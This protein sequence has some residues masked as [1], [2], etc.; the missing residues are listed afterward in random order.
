MPFNTSPTQPEVLIV[1]AGPAGLA[2]AIASARKGLHVEVVDAMQPPIDKACGEGLLPDAL[3][4]LTN[5]GFNLN[6]DLRSIETHPLRGIRFLNEQTTTEASFPATLGR[7]IRRTVLHQLLLDRALSL[8]VR[9]HWQHSVQSIEPTT[10][11]HLIRTNRQTLRTRYLIGA[12]GHHS[13]IAAWSGLTASTTH[14]R[15]IGLRQHYTI[16]PWTNF[17]EVYWSNYGQAYVTPTSPHEVCVAFVSNQKTPSTEHALAQ[18]PALQHQLTAA[19]PSGSPRGSISLNR[20]LRRVTANNIALIGDASGSVDAITG[21]G[22]GLGFSQAA[23]LAHALHTG[24]LA[25]YQRA[26]SSIQRP[27][28]I[29]SRSLLLLDRFPHLRTL[30]LNTFERHPLLF[31]H[32]LHV[33]IGHRNCPFAVLTNRLQPDYTC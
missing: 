8:G 25:S 5:L 28:R 12:D 15:R 31:E 21:S 22:L 7:G 1:G 32:L 4:S 26:H 17:V 10:S 29:M 6:H 20:T 30:T 18:F 2:A 16:A 14:S 33:H 24:N 11:G 9:F 19:T 27:A 23:A 3:C 13:R